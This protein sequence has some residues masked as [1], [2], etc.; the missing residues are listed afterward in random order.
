MATGKFGR[1][2]QREEPA[3]AA[4][5]T[6]AKAK[7]DQ[8]YTLLLSAADRAAID[9]DVSRLAVATDLPVDRS[10]VTRILYR[11]LHED[12]SLFDEVKRHALVV[13]AEK[14]EERR[15][16]ARKA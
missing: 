8:K 16:A 10:D 14:I 11:L 15:R 1:L 12:Q 7:P 3:T 9:A 5:E 13:V 2:V 6:A 4:A